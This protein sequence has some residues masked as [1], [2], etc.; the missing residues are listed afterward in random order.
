[1]SQAEKHA[2][3]DSVAEVGDVQVL[4]ESKPP[5]FHLQID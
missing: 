1:M 3:L 2:F 4:D 5:H